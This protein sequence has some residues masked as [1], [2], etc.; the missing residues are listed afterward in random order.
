MSAEVERPARM[1][2]R[3]V[4]RTRAQLRTAFTSLMAE[5]PINQITV[6]ELADRADVNRGTFYTHYRDIYDMLEQVEQELLDELTAVLDR[7]SAQELRR[8][9]R[10]VLEEVFCFVRENAAL[11]TALLSAGER[12]ALGALHGG[13]ERNLSPPGGG[14]A[15]KLRHAVSGGGDGGSGAQ[16]DRPGLC[17]GPGDHGCAD[18]AAHPLGHP[19]NKKAETGRLL[20]TSGLCLGK[21]IQ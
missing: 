1:E 9:I 5:K 6:R 21:R 14:R 11:C 18:R 2:D 12:S 8:G 16:L 20:L 13:V 7:Y 3:R 19:V 17:R 10:P 4:R 15:G